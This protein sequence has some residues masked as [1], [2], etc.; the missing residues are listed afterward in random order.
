MNL[1]GSN[2][3]Q[4]SSIERCRSWKYEEFYST[5]LWKFRY[6]YQTVQLKIFYIRFVAV[7]ETDACVEGIEEG[8]PLGYE[9]EY[10]YSNDSYSMVR[11]TSRRFTSASK[12]LEHAARSL[13]KP[14]LV[15]LM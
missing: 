7:V 11:Q 8:A 13:W 14:I 3:H 1:N 10:W 6:V 9:M 2:I 12:F 15:H 4:H 5:K